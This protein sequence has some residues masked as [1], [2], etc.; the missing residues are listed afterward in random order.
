LELSDG[1]IKPGKLS[2]TRDSRLKIFDEA[3]K[4]HRDV[5]L[6]A[7][8]RIDC[9]VLK[10][11]VE[12]EWRFKENVND[13]KYFTGRTYPVREYTHK[14]TLQNGQ[15]IQGSLSAIVYVQTESAQNRDRFLL[16]KRDKGELGT[17][18]RSLVYVRSIRIGA[19]SLEEG[20]RKGA[21]ESGSALRG[22][23][24]ENR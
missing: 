1:T 21:K 10:E 14:I 9:T 17:D 13:E 18:L 6:K 22:R 4:R 15:T 5:P 8:K 7:I 19:N 24:G 23:A 12:K 16:H 3:R 20:K 2:L 11:W